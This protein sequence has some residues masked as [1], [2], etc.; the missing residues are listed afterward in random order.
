[1]HSTLVA[2]P[3]LSIASLL[4]STDLETLFPTGVV[5]VDIVVMSAG[6][7]TMDTVVSILD[8]LGLGRPTDGSFEDIVT[9]EVFTV[10]G[11]LLVVVVFADNTAVVAGL[12][13]S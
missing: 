12:L 3:S 1:M 5:D 6:F 11:V 7:V 10:E 4:T 13:I 8:G 2:T 9:V